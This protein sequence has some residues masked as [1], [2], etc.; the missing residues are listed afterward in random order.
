MWFLHIDHMLLVQ[1]EYIACLQAVLPF[2]ELPPGWVAGVVDTSLLA[3]PGIDLD[4]RGTP[5]VGNHSWY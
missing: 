3:G 4:T 1:A 5:A 2:L